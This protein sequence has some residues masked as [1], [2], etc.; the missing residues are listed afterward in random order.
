MD[1]VNSEPMSRVNVKNLTN[2]SGTKTNYRGTFSINVEN[3]DYLQF[4]YQGFRSRIIRVR[5]IKEVDFLRV[6]LAI[7]RT[8]LKTLTITKPLTE[9]QQDSVERAEIYRDI[10]K[11]E[12]ATSIFSP[13]STIQ[14]IFSKK[15]KRQRHF[16]AQVLSIEK[17][18]FIDSRYTPELAAKVT[19]LKGD[20]LAYFMNAY[21]MDLDYARTA[22]DLEIY[23]WIAR[24][25]EEYQ[26]VNP[27]LG[28][29]K[30]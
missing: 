5:D 14:Q 25:W 20:E 1:S 15:H 10:F 7:G 8:E 24:N 9:Y 18:K 2:K 23:S 26:K 28:K 4:S 19:K 6:K 16:K 17:Q 13:V 29:E 11:Y 30:P 12:R 3:G 27:G 22:G 21:P